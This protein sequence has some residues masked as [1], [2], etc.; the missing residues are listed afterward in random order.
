MRKRKKK[1]L[2]GGRRRRRRRKIAAAFEAASEDSQPDLL[3]DPRREQPGRRART[4]QTTFSTLQG[5]CNFYRR[6]ASRPRD[7][8]IPRRQTQTTTDFELSLETSMRR[9]RVAKFSQ[10][11]RE[12]TK[13][14]KREG[15]ERR[16]EKER[17]RT[18][19]RWHY[20]RIEVGRL[21]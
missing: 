11:P 21:R 18:R 2:M 3:P 20:R 8:T 16:G 7:A 1:K 14:R 10:K 4:G 6:D 17:E 9:T 5:A 19:K 15:K 13:Q 12:E